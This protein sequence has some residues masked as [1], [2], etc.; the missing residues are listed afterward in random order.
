MFGVKEPIW[1]N[2]SYYNIRYKLQI[3]MTLQMP[4]KMQQM[5]LIHLIF[6]T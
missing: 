1:P 5:A 4:A 6:A 2:N 3:Q